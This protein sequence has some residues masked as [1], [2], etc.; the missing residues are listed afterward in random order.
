MLHLIPYYNET[1]FPLLI[2]P[3]NIYLSNELYDDIEINCD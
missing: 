1:R 2:N 3:R